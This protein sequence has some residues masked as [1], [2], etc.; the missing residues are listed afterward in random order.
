MGKALC[1]SI[2]NTSGR[3]QALRNQKHDPLKKK[4]PQVVRPQPK[5]KRLPSDP[6]AALNG[7]EGL[8]KGTAH[9]NQTFDAVVC[10]GNLGIF[11]A[12][13]LQQRGYRVC[14][15]DKG[16]IRGRRQ[17]WNVSREASMMVTLRP[18]TVFSSSSFE[19]IP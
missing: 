12:A 7:P 15:V 1:P 5:G 16:A 9:E 2:P 18:A 6:T 3:P 4:G 19:G 10:G 14:V 8:A 17:E 11:V 13:T